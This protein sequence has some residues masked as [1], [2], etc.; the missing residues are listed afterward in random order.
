MALKHR[1][2]LLA[3][4]ILAISALANSPSTGE[5][6]AGGETRLPSGVVV[7]IDDWPSSAEELK[8]KYKEMFGAT[9][10]GRKNTFEALKSAALA[11][12]RQTK[13]EIINALNYTVQSICDEYIVYSFMP[14]ERLLPSTVRE[15][16][17]DVL[18]R[19]GRRS[20]EKC[21]YKVAQG[22]KISREDGSPLPD[23]ALET[24]QLD[25]S[26]S[27]SIAFLSEMNEADV[28]LPVADILIVVPFATT[29]MLNLAPYLTRVAQKLYSAPAYKG[30]IIKFLATEKDVSKDTYSLPS[31]MV[32]AFK[33]ASGSVVFVE[34]ITFQRVP[35]RN[36]DN[37]FNE[38]IVIPAWNYN[39]AKAM[40]VNQTR[41][42]LKYY[43]SESM[44]RDST[45]VFDAIGPYAAEAF[46]VS[47]VF[48][49]HRATLAS[50]MF[51]TGL[52]AVFES[53]NG[54]WRIS[55]KPN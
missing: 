22:P 15:I 51:I 24:L 26:A 9:V 34:R 14:Y 5:N 45:E 16:V 48:V 1:H 23:I 10:E 55:N 52:R 4:I 32:M 50:G 27:A 21:I 53:D 13:L 37:Q 44:I 38:F 7:R 39:L 31:L 3:A 18:D 30:I 54:V 41:E 2:F 33:T 35:V 20:E 19:Q 29:D 8:R 12:K 49:S 25:G 46:K 47:Q 28:Q 36:Q 42:V 40:A 11:A 43:T 6:L 17:I